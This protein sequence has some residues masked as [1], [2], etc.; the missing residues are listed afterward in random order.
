MRRQKM[1]YLNKI[2]FINSANVPYS[3]IKLD[4]NVHFIGTQGVG[5][6]TLLRAILFFYNADKSKLGIKTQGKQRSYDEFYFDKSDSYIIYEVCRENGNFMVMTLRKKGRVAYRF[7][8]CG[9]HKEFFIDEN[10]TPFFEWNMIS[11]KIGP[12]VYKSR[13]IYSYA[14][15]RDIIYGNHKGQVQKE[16]RKFCILE[17]SR[18]EN[19]YRTIQNIF[20]NQSLESRVIKDTIID[21]MDFAGDSI[22]LNFY[23][24]HVKD[25]KMQY[26]D[27]WKWFDE[28]NG[29]VK[30][31]DLAN[32]VIDKYAIYISLKSGIRELCGNLNYVMK[33]DEAR[34]PEITGDLEQ[35]REDLS[36]Q[37]RLLSE[38][39]KKHNEQRDDLNQKKGVIDAF[40][41]TCKERR[42]HYEAIGIS[43]I[44]RRVE[45]E[46]EVKIRQEGLQRQV[47]LLTS[48]NKDV[49]SKYDSLIKDAENQYRE[50]EIQAKARKNA[51]NKELNETNQSYR[52]D[53]ENHIAETKTQFNQIL[54]DNQLKLTSAQDHKHE[55]EL[56]AVKAEQSNPYNDVMCELEER[57]SR[58]TKLEIELKEQFNE[59]Q[60]NI[61]TITNDTN[62]KRKDLENKCDKDINKIEHEVDSIKHEISQCDDLLQRQ[63]GSLA[64][65]LSENVDRW[66]NTIGKILDED[67][68]LYNTYLNPQLSND[69]GTVLG[70]KI[71]IENIEKTVRTPQDIAASRQQHEENLRQLINKIQARKQELQ[72]S[73]TTME[74]KPSARLKQLRQDMMNLTA[75]IEQEIPTAIKN[76]QNELS[77]KQDLL[78][79][80]HEQQRETVLSQ[81]AVVENDIIK[82]NEER[83]KTIKR[84]ENQLEKLSKDCDKLIKAAEEQAAKEIDGIT[85]DLK[86]KKNDTEKTKKELTAQMDNELKGLGVD[87]GRLE[88]LRNDLGKCDD[89]LAFIDGRRSDY[90][91]WKKDKSEYFAQEANKKEEQKLVKCKLDNLQMK[92]DLRKEKLNKEIN[93]LKTLRDELHSENHRLENGIIKA[94]H[95]VGSSSCPQELAT[96]GDKETVK[97]LEDVLN[98]LRDNIVFQQRR[99]EEFRNATNDFKSHFS[100]HNTF[101]FPTELNGDNDYID[102][103]AQLNDFLNNNKIE[104]YRVRTSEMYAHIIN[105]VAREVSDISNHNADIKKTIDDI[106]KDF[107]ENNF[108]GV[109]KEIELRAVESNDRLM[110]QLMNIKRF[111]DENAFNLGQLNLFT[112]EGTNEDTNKEAVKLLMRLIELMDSEPKR[113]LITLSDTFKLEFKV[114]ENDNTTNWVE[115]LSNVGSDGTDVLVKAMVNIMLLNVFKVKI[116]RKFGDF[117]LH[118]MMDEIGKLHPDNVAG[119]LNFAN[120]RNIFLIN[121]S[122]TTYNA[123][124]YKY[125]YTLSKDSNSK[126]IVKKL[127]T[128]Q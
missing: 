49:K 116:S 127:L 119:I 64:E 102:F 11:E 4:G 7:I 62:L 90:I 55:L 53:L 113:E 73:I 107:K 69:N 14:E 45:A 66:E 46:G 111:D 57:Q 67:A 20:L 61:D 110:Q 6:S 60:K 28:K 1:R 5:K 13:I 91:S 114:K 27:I 44:A 95:F 72:E 117:K 51:I 115:K 84:L 82:Y 118:C 26:E 52:K 99:L 31:K 38:E 8:D 98:S 9:Y 76:A 94:R 128:I 42:Q 3:E 120:V 18:Y 89:E 87:T 34:L 71:D 63:H 58:L 2:I 121:S 83:T 109:I 125:T 36:R 88:K 40:L 68:V 75:R 126:T 35:C 100:V 79:Q 24:E 93:R 15:Y 78:K 86:E 56:Q 19:V 54:E 21:S 104:E 23:R 59:I 30:V 124:S 106:N 70:V 39:T 10:G 17:S 50:L 43:E 123:Q 74:Q 65:W 32:K 37:E 122:P 92:F 12:K 80:W 96:A 77:Q 25:F 112:N 47:D 48:K 22:D 103:A 16:L 29:R 33:R 101:H 85:S 81:R 105:R 41:K 108:A 97:D